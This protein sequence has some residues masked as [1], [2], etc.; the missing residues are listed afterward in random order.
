LFT[1]SERCALDLESQLFYATA[2]SVITVALR[3]PSLATP[4]FFCTSELPLYL[5]YAALRL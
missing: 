3:P 2:A 4:P 5:L 1:T